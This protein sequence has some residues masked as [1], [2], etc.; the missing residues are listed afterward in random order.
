MNLHLYNIG[1][2]YHCYESIEFGASIV[3]EDIDIK[4]VMDFITLHHIGAVPHEERYFTLHKIETGFSRDDEE[5]ILTEKQSAMF[6]LQF[7]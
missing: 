2:M 6:M 5:Y 4:E 1:N 3:I 7:G